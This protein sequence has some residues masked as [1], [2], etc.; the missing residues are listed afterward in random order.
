MIKKETFTCIGCPIGCTL[1]VT[2]HDLENIVVEGNL[3]AIGDRYGK[4]EIVSPVRMV[5]S[6]VLVDE[7]VDSLVPVK[8]DKEINKTLM[9][10]LARALAGVKVKAPVHIGDVLVENILDSGVNMIATSEVLGKE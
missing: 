2:M 1:E 10:E 5:T 9:V 4:K 8:T 6:T 7:G 3:C